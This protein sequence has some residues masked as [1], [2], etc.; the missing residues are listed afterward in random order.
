M[1]FRRKMDNNIRSVNRLINKTL[2]SNISVY[3]LKS[4]ALPDIGRDIFHIRRVSQQIIYLKTIFR[5]LPKEMLKHVT[6][7]KTRSASQKN[8]FFYFF[9]LHK[10]FFPN[11]LIGCGIP[12][13]FDHSARFLYKRKCLFF[14]KSAKECFFTFSA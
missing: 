2:I 7:N 12:T 9:F 5:I 11:I 14:K 10:I 13:F 6:S 1:G 8:C 3:K 4:L